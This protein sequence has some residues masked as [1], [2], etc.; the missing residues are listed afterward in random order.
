[1]VIEKMLTLLF[2][3]KTLKYEKHFFFI[4]QGVLNIRKKLA[5]ISQT[6]ECEETVKSTNIMY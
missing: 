2:K 6:C 5:N 1:M 4:L 3:K